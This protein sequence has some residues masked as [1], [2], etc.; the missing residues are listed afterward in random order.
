MDAERALQ[1]TQSR[2]R[3]IRELPSGLWAKISLPRVRECIIAGDIPRGVL[4][5]MADMAKASS[6]G[7]VKELTEADEDLANEAT[8]ESIRSLVFF[9][10]RLVKAALKGLGLTD[11]EANESDFEA[12]DEL[13]ASLVQEDFDQI[14]A[15]AKRD[16]DIDPKVPTPVSETSPDTP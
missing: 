10:T 4:K 6:N 8:L 2:N 16:E 15:W 11:Y 1:L 5:M 13:V 12:T 14:A 3:Y 9:Q 7:E